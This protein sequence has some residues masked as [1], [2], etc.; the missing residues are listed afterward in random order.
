[1]SAGIGLQVGQCN[2][3]V[4]SVGARLKNVQSGTRALGGDH[5]LEIWIE[6]RSAQGFQFLVQLSRGRQRRQIGARRRESAVFLGNKSGLF[7]FLEG[8]VRQ[9]FASRGLV[10]IS[11]IC[12]EKLGE[13]EDFRLGN[14]TNRICAKM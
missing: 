12:P 6:K 7:Q 8:E 10:M 2:A 4:K 1:M 5:G 14:R 13:A 3:L 9:E 11:A